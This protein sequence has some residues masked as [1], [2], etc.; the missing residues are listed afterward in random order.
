MLRYTYWNYR[1]MDVLHTCLICTS[2][3][4]YLIA[5]WGNVEMNREGFVPM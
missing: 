4:Q 1:V 2:A 3:W 5:N